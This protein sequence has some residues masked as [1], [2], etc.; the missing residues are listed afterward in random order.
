[1]LQQFQRVFRQS[2]ARITGQTDHTVLIRRVGTSSSLGPDR[3][4]ERLREGASMYAVEKRSK[5][6]REEQGSCSQ[7]NAYRS[8]QMA[9]STAT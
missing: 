3:W 7:A 4:A 1:M 9:R 2:V 6:R 8:G 5:E